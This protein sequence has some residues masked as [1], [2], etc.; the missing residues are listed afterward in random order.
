MDFIS[1][2]KLP[3][4]NINFISSNNNSDIISSVL[5]M[6]STIPLENLSSS[7]TLSMVPS[8]ESLYIPIVRSVDK[9]LSSLPK[10]ISMTEDFLRVCIG[11]HRIDTLKKHFT[12]LYQHTVKLDNSPADAVLDPGY[13]V[14]MHKKIVIL[15]LFL[16]LYNLVMSY[17][18]TLYL[19]QK[20][21]WEI[22]IMACF[23]WIILEGCLLCIHFRIWLLIFRN[24]C[25]H[26]LPI[27]VLY[28]IRLFLIWY[29][30]YWR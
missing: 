20:S 27:L 18:L 22:Y 23:V 13:L 16:V 11:Y 7:P 25:S 8:S 1:S 2:S 24:N 19:V 12:L 29:E 4:L 26:F 21:L 5:N 14:S 30:A 3:E 6:A 10:N 9:P 17:I 15:I 28:L